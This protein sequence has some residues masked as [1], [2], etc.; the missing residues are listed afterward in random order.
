M[1]ENY[2]TLIMVSVQL[3]AFAFFY[4]LVDK[5]RKLSKKR[6]GFK[7]LGILI[8]SQDHFTKGDLVKMDSIATDRG[9]KSFGPNVYAD[10]FPYGFFITITD[11]IDQEEDW[12]IPL[13]KNIVKYA[14]KEKCKYILIDEDGPYNYDVQQI[15]REFK[16]R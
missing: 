10:R 8:I 14:L 16:N 3:I 6:N 1:M 2:S 11:D 13:M 15:I 12:K 7:K 5:V 4:L 9:L